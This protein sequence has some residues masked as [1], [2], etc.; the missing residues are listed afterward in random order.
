MRGAKSVGDAKYTFELP[1]PH[2]LFET[3]KAAQDF[4]RDKL[5]N[6]PYV[7][8]E[9]EGPGRFRVRWRIGPQI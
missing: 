3:R 8:F 4:I 9:K 2:R 5:W 6:A 1:M 7:S